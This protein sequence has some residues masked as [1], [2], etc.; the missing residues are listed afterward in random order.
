VSR[1]FEMMKKFFSL[2]SKKPEPVKKVVKPK[3]ASGNARGMG[4][5]KKDVKALKD[6]TRGLNEDL[7]AIKKH[8]ESVKDYDSDIKKFHDKHEAHEKKFETHAEKFNSVES[9]MTDHKIELIE[10]KSRLNELSHSLSRFEP[11]LA[12]VEEIEKRLVEEG[13]RV[14]ERVAVKVARAKASAGSLLEQYHSLAP[15]TKKIFSLLLNMHVGQKGKWIA[16]SDLRDLVYPD[17][18]GK[19][20]TQAAMAKAIRPLYESE[21]VEK[22]RDK[23]F[24]YVAATK[25][26]REAAKEAGLEQ[27][28][29][30]FDAAFAKLE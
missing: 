18:E 13:P 1:C 26:G 8:V 11:L 19:N 5:L 2:F 27:Q 3:A 24:V 12:K 25:K 10:L 4:V 22:K 21:F 29:E 30:K 20:S 23:S 16:L 14:S 6:H 15:S 28:A 9:K 7:V 17:N